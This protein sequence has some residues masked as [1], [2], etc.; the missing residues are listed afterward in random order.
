MGNTISSTMMKSSA[1]AVD[2]LNAREVGDAIRYLG[3]GRAKLVTLVENSLYK[4]GKRRTSKGL[5]GKRSVSQVRYEMF[6][7]SPRPHTFTVASGTEI[8]ST[9]VT[10]ASVN[11]L[12]A[13]FT[14]INSSNNT[15]CRVESVNTSTK[16]IKGSSYGDTTFSCEA[17]DVLILGA[18]AMPEGSTEAPVLNGS[19]DN[20]FNMLQFSRWSVTISWVLEAIKQLAGGN[21]LS[22]EKMYLLH[23]AMADMERSMIL[24]DYSGDYATKNTTTGVQTGYT[25]EYPTCRGIYHMAANS[26]SFDGSTTLSKLRKDLPLAMDSSINDEDTFIA[27]VGNE[28]YARIQELFNDKHT[29]N[30]SEGVLKQFGIKSD[31][32]ITSGPNIQLVKHECMNAGGY[33]NQMIVFAPENLGYV[34]LKGHDFKPNNGIQTNATHGKQDELYAYWGIETLDAG[35]SIT[36]IQ[37]MF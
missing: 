23:S 9:G 29:N 15:Q 33:A 28:N 11:G 12:P 31:K 5:I 30:D 18:P 2:Q 21:R 1:P 7:R 36:V 32:I 35:K 13:Y 14:L 10:L 19:D 26:T 4:G 37:N 22:R 6:T 25:G 20:N 3:I 24:G 8:S 27:Y 34:S 17:G 16:V